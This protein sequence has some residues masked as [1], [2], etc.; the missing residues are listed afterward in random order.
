[1]TYLSNCDGMNKLLLV[2]SKQQPKPV[3]GFRS[4]WSLTVNGMYFG[5]VPIC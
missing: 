1:M 3:K 5:P 4:W 2:L